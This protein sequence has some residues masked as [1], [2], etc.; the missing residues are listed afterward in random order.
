MGEIV[1]LTSRAERDDQDQAISALLELLE[2]DIHAGRR[3]RSLSEELA[4]AVLANSGHAVNLDDEIKGDV[5]L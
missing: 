1:T 2:A 3:M 5:A 4:R